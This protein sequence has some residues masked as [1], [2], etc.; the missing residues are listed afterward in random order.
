MALEH[1]GTSP[2]DNILDEKDGLFWLKKGEIYWVKSNK[3]EKDAENT[4]KYFD[5]AIQLEPL[6]YLAWANKG[7]ILKMLGRIEDA[8]ACY[9]RALDIQPMYVNAWY[10]KGVLLGSMGK[11]KTAKRCFKQVLALDP[12]NNLAKRDMK[13]LKEILKKKKK[14]R[15]KN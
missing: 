15:M 9:D 7:L 12:N 4:L 5:K 13:V 8:L 1:H 10:N 2:S 6:N 3:T 11:Y 14:K